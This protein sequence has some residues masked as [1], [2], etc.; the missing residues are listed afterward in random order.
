MI[1]FL[2]S[3]CTAATVIAVLA[4]VPSWRQRGHRPPIAP[5]AITVLKPLC[6]AD[7]SLAGNLETFFTQDYPAFELVFGVVDAADP[8]LLVVEDLIA[9]HPTVAARVI[10][11]DGRHGLNPKVANLRGMLA[12]GAHDVVVISDSNVAV[13]PGYLRS[14]VETLAQ[15][16]VGLVTSLIS[17]AGERSLGARLEGLHLCGAVAASVAAAEDLT[18]DALVVGKSLCFR[19]SVFESLGGM[20]SLAAV[21]AEDYVM[22]RMFTEAGWRVRLSREAVA[23]VTVETTVLAFLRRQA[24]WALLRSRLMPLA[25]PFEALINPAAVGACAVLLGAPALPVL[26][27]ALAVATAR[28]AVAWGLTRG[29]RGAWVAALALPKD[30]LVLGAWLAAPWKRHVSWRGRRFRVSAGTRLFSQT[31]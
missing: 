21:L 23:N 3:V 4:L 27:W 18:G 29:S 20:E 17:A 6:G 11:H 13:G 25:Y 14:L 19:R 10:I 26:L 8:A 12:A 30:V 22:G 15:P 28:D 9:A 2:L 5:P 31:R 1:V 7:A 16:G 24:R